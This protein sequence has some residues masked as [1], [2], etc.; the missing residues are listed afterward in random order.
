MTVSPEATFLVSRAAVSGQQVS[1][2]APLTKA[3]STL[4]PLGTNGKH[5]ARADYTPLP[6]GSMCAWV[7]TCVTLLG[8]RAQRLDHC[9]GKGSPCT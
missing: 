8:A 9:I 4:R 6:V 2:L 1:P 7:T 3:P 5:P